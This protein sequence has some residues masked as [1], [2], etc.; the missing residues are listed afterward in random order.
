MRCLLDFDGSVHSI[1]LDISLDFHSMEDTCRYACSFGAF[2]FLERD[3]SSLP[4]DE[5]M[6][7]YLGSGDFHH[8]T[9]LLLRRRDPDSRV[10]LVVFD[11][12]PD[13]M[14]FPFGIHCGSWVSHASQLPNVSAVSVVG[15]ASGDIRGWHVLEN[16][17][18]PLRSRKIMYFCPGDVTSW[19]SAVSRGGIC[20]LDGSIA[21]ALAERDSSPVYV[22]IDKDVLAPSEVTTNWD[23]GVMSRELLLS[24]LRELS[25]NVVAADITGEYSTHRYRK[26]WKR[27]MTAFEGQAGISADLAQVQKRHMNLN[28]EIAEALKM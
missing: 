9:Y 19:A 5:K 3:M 13:N 17:L 25:S 20:R 2:D 27:L 14:V 4:R 23:Q 12:H 8:I 1:P 26:F 21:E 24:T 16:H 7:A 10:H 15:V 11:N 18:R 22:S 28:Q 6:L